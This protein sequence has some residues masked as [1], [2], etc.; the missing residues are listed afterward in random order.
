MHV[1]ENVSQ[2]SDYGQGIGRLM[3][4]PMGRD[5]EESTIAEPFS[6]SG[7][8]GMKKKKARCRKEAEWE[9]IGVK[10]EEKVRVGI[11]E[12]LEESEQKE[13]DWEEDLS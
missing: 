7:G 9:E 6:G 4:A 2:A 10:V 8:A 1:M 13:E 12:W 3:Q 5:I 11:K